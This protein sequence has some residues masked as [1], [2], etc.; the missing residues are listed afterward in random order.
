MDS[1]LLVQD[2]VRGQSE[3]LENG[4]EEVGLLVVL[5]RLLRGFLRLVQSVSCLLVNRLLKDLAEESVRIWLSSQLQNL[6]LVGPHGLSVVVGS[7]LMRLNL[8]LAVL[9][10]LVDELVELLRPTG[11]LVLFA[12]AVVHV[13]RGN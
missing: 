2:S 11:T 6:A 3:L 4:S 10:H 9:L 8:G 13:V 1:C 5:F 7:V 12:L